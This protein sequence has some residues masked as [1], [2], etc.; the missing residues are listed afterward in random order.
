M[1]IT[2]LPAF[3]RQRRIVP[4]LKPFLELS[5]VGAVSLTSS[6]AGAWRWRSI[7]N[8]DRAGR[9]DPPADVVCRHCHVDPIRWGQHAD[10]KGQEGDDGEAAIC[11]TVVSDFVT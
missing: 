10:E 5:D 11:A 1:V 6:A 2:R 8:H 9:R 7:A 3:H 4:S